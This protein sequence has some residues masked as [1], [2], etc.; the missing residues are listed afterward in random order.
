MIKLIAIVDA[1]FGIAKNNEIPWSFK[2]DRIFFAKN[3]E[4]SV[5]VMGR[6]TFF[7]IPHLKN[8]ICCVLSKTNISGVEVFSSID[9][10]LK[11]HDDFWVI[12][13]AEIYNEFL[14][15]ELIE[16]ALITEMKN[17]FFADTFMDRS[18]LT[19]FT[20]KT[21]TENDK[22]SINEYRKY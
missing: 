4:N 22:Y 2:E 16:Y 13:G 17:R 19:A 8:R 15:R 20:Q 9:S 21:L 18:L 6:K 3:T 11:E 5:L 10:L 1:D 14:K 12:G 7:T